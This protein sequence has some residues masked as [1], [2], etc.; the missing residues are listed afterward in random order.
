MATWRGPEEPTWSRL[1]IHHYIRLALRLILWLVVTGLLVIAYYIG[2]AVD[3]IAPKLGASDSVV[4]LWS[5]FSTWTVGLTLEVVGTPMREAGARV[6]NHASW[7][8]I[9]VIRAA[10]QI[11]FVAKS[12][13]KV[14]PLIGWLANQTKTLFIERKRSEAKAQEALFMGRL[15]Q[16]HRLCFFPEGTSSDGL[17][18]LP[19]KSTL[20]N[21]FM[22]PAMREV[23]W[24]QPI[25]TIYQP[26]PHLP[27]NFYGW[28]GGM[29]FAGHMIQVFARSTKGRVK[30]VFHDP[31][32][33]SEFTDRKALCRYCDEKVRGAMDQEMDA[34]GITPP[35]SRPDPELEAV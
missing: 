1:G 16:G 24:V 27:V 34:R 9:F 32:R 28:W 10:A 6:G 14:W 17:R 21:V 26:A 3:V 2:R 11:Y 8:D 13:V 31:V 7:V 29:S 22:T 5:A 4:W 30:V 19:F 20:F 25:T 33:A 18:V 23:S 15:D 12:E 35:P